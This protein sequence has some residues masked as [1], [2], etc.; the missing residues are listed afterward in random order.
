MPVT[1]LV[2]VDVGVRDA[3]L[4]AVAFDEILDN[5]DGLSVFA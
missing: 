3:V 4:V 2:E 1:G 5:P